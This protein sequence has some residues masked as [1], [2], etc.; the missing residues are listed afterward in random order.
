MFG[1]THAKMPFINIYLYGVEFD[2]RQRKLSFNTACVILY[3]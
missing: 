2:K 3:D 1:R